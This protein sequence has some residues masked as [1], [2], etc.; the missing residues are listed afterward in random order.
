MRL[1]PQVWQKTPWVLRFF[2]GI[3]ATTSNPRPSPTTSPRVPPPTPH[4]KTKLVK[5]YHPKISSRV[6]PS[7][8]DESSPSLKG[9]W[10]THPR[11]VSARARGSRVGGT[12]T[13]CNG[14]VP[15]RRR[16]PGDGL[17]HLDFRFRPLGVVLPRPGGPRDGIHRL[18]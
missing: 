3:L 17:S 15:Y 8:Q 5:I 9:F 10:Y 11:R 14:R 4:V 6:K 7:F 2:Y 13:W 12:E 18:P 1:V 16:G